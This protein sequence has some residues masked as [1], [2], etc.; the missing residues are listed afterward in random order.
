MGVTLEYNSGS[1]RCQEGPRKRSDLTFVPGLSDN[2]TKNAQIFLG[3]DDG[4]AHL[5]PSTSLVQVGQRN[6]MAE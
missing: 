4:N 1:Y 6:W 2:A 5:V 3:R